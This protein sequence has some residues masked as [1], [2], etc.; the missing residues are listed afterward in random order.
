MIGSAVLQV[1]PDPVFSTTAYNPPKP[2][3]T[4]WLYAFGEYEA[5]VLAKMRRNVKRL[6]LLVGYP[7][8]F[9]NPAA[10]VFY[11]NANPS[12]KY[13]ASGTVTENVTDGAIVVRVDADD[14]EKALPAIRST[15][16]GW[17]VSTDGV[18]YSPALP[19]GIPTGDEL[20]RVTVPLTPVAGHEG[21]YDAGREVL[22]GIVFHASRCPSFTAG[23]SIHE[24]LHVTPENQEQT[25]ELVDDGD[26]VWRTPLPLAF[27]YILVKSGE[28]AAIEVNAAYTPLLYRRTYDFGDEE[29]NRI[30]ACSAYTL[31]LCINTFQIDG[32]KRDR[33]PWGG[34]LAIS[35]L[36]NAYSFREPEP[37]RRTLTVLGRDGTT[38]SH[39]NGI[40]DYSLWAVISHE[41]YQKYFGDMDFLK[42]SYGAITQILDSFIERARSD[43][44]FIRPTE[45]DWCFIDWVEIEKST[46]LQ[47]LFHWALV[48]GASL[49]RRMD[50][51]ATAMRYTAEAA[52]LRTRI[53]ESALD[54]ETGLYRGSVFD[55]ASVPVRHANFLAVLAGVADA[56]PASH[57]EETLKSLRASASSAALRDN[58]NPAPNCQ[59]VKPSNRQTASASIAE[60]L[61]GDALPEAGTPYMLSLEIWALHLLGHTDEALAKLRRIWGGMLKLGATTFFEGWRDDFDEITSCIFYDRPFGMSLCHAWSSAPCALLPMLTKCAKIES[62][63]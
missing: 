36:A 15:E 42:R 22:A 43:G 12:A 48:S 6:K 21:L 57:P 4:G 18:E 56:T 31:R 60:A 63:R 17:E 52:A 11:R 32:V 61:L 45:K 51:E 40:M 47:M 16:D 35:L 9:R 55:K 50:D 14:I 46:A 7:G 5:F 54:P 33:L 3:P 8:V 20:P 34:D 37:I 29:L 26:G 49:A 23:E 39:V 27:R 30:W 24:A 59:T 19:G 41:F 58:S 1:T 38:L 25:F 2:P 44:G 13:E 62:C 28:P 53:N 10:T